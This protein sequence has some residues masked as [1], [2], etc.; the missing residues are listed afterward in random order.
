MTIPPHG[1]RLV[2]RVLTEGE[3]RKRIAEAA[4]L[5]KLRPF[6]DDVY[7]AEKI[8]LGA[9]SPL[10]GFMDRATFEGVLS[11]SRL[12]GGLPWTM[13]ILLTPPGPANAEVIGKLTG[14]D[15]VALLDDKD[16]PFAV[17]HVTETFRPDK[18]AWA[19]ATY[20][21]TDPQHPNVADIAA[22]GE[23]AVAGKVD[24][25]QRLDLPT[26]PAEM[27][28]AETRELF[29]KKGWKRV[30]A[31]QCRN[32]PHTAHEYLQRLTL[33]RDDVDALLIH[34]VVGRLKKGDYRPEII[35]DAYRALTANYHSPDRVHLAAFSIA[36]RY[37]GP[38]AA[39]FLAIVRQNFGCSSYIVGRDQAG[40]GKYYDP[41]ACHKIFD[42][43]P[44]EIQALRYDEAWLCR[45]CGWMATMKTCPHPAS[46][47]VDTSQTRIRK[48][49]GGAEPLP[50][51]ILRPEVA[52]ILRRPDVTL[53]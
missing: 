30:A 43:L 5:P 29:A 10:E 41:Y 37:A 16:R 7:D 48:A 20:A 8:A 1:G 22:A 12:P 49:L 53:G 11:S 26:G 38:R 52:E 2:H 23:V 14:G 15:D 32:P 45:K 25:L 13:P 36:M 50:A 9:Y 18:T 33:E 44:L 39:L 27:T 17:V 4:D 3:A 21:T 19:R 51:E 34:P 40:V 42:E 35:L 47:R 24:L 31:Y 28:P 46:D 6:V